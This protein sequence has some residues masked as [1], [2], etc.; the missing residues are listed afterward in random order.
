MIHRKKLT[1]PENRMLFR[2]SL[3]IHRKQLTK[4]ILC[5]LAELGDS[6]EETGRKILSF[7]QNLETGEF[8]VLVQRKKLTEK[9][10]CL[11]AEPGAA[12]AQKE[13]PAVQNR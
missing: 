10:L 1:E 3:V 13:L 7:W 2:Q 12:E 6:Q 9:I 4:K 11:L 5:P 8:L